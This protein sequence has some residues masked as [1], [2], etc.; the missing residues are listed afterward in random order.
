MKEVLAMIL[1]G[2]RGKRMDVLCR[3]RPKPL[4]PFGSKFRIIDFTLSNCVNS[5]LLNVAVLSS[6]RYTQIMDYMHA[7]TSVNPGKLNLTLFNSGD[8]PYRGTADAL[9]QN[10]QYLRQHP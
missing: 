4:L 2:G 5:G 10:I 9:Y 7:W 8:I 1:A 6:Y 3:V